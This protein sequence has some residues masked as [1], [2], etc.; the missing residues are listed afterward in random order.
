MTLMDTI[1]THHLTGQKHFNYALIAIGSHVCRL[2]HARFNRVQTIKP[3]SS[4]KQ[5]LILL[6]GFHGIAQL[7]ERV[8]W[9]LMTQDTLTT[10]FVWA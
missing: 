9:L 1:K 5:N 6:V 2:E 4:N 7:I 3:R 8:I 10:V